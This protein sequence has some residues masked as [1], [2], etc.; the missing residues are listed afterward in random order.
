[1]HNT[2]KDGAM[3]GQSNI[4]AAVL[5]IS[6]AIIISIFVGNFIISTSK[7]SSLDIVNQT[8]R[9]LSCM[10]TSFSIKNASFDTN[11]DCTQGVNH[12]LNILV[13]NTGQNKV[14]IDNIVI[15]KNEGKLLHFH[16]G[17]N[18]SPGDTRTLS[19]RSDE[20]CVGIV[21]QVQ[22][23]YEGKVRRIIIGSEDCSSF[24]SIPGT[25]LSF[26]NA[27]QSENRK[28]RYLMALWHFNSSLEDSSGN[29]N[30]GTAMNGGGSYVGGVNELFGNSLKF[31]GGSSYVEVSDSGSLDITNQTTIM[32]WLYSG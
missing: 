5:L 12:T 10:Y 29:N 27:N 23:G 4:M 31:N 17:Q 25:Y 7:S 16:G 14:K 2:I 30:Y 21:N 9:R 22:G 13:K 19:F 15:E 24:D 6:I 8:S 28:S 20:S 18:I 1:M 32:F 3:K 26:L 11:L